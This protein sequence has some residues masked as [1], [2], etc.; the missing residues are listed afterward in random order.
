MLYPHPHS[1]FDH[2]ANAASALLVGL[3]FAFVALNAASGCGQPGGACIAVKDLV[4]QP[5]ATQLA[6]RV[7]GYPG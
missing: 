2:L 4:S 3:V 6:R 1:V 7:D 5:P